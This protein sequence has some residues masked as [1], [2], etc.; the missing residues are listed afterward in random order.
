MCVPQGFE[1]VE[2]PGECCGK[3]EQTHCIIKR[4]GKEPIILK[5]SEGPAPIPT[6]E[7]PARSHGQGLGCLPPPQQGLPRAGH[8]CSS[9]LGWP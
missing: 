1:L 2:A 8:G 6:Q 5:V 3:C 7:G 9:V 4:P